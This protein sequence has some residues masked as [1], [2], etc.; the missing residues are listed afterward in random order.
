VRV[1]AERDVGGLLL[2]GVR[3]AQVL[4]VE[5]HVGVGVADLA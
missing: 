3:I 1:D 4:R 2:D 5:A